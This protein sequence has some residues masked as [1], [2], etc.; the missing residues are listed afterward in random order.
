MSA[1]MAVM[2]LVRGIGSGTRQK[3]ERTGATQKLER[4]GATHLT[5][6]SL[7][8]SEIFFLPGDRK[9]SPVTTLLPVFSSRSTR[10]YCSCDDATLKAGTGKSWSASKPVEPKRRIT[11]RKSRSY[12]DLAEMRDTP[13]ISIIQ[14]SAL[15]IYLALYAVNL[16][17]RAT[18]SLK[19]GNVARSSGRPI[20]AT[21]GAP[22]LTLSRSY[23]RRIIKIQGHLT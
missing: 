11:R 1:G 12:L 5:S 6:P 9:F 23:N 10:N 3:L 7:H 20:A 15:H 4:T 2:S 14:Y 21:A 16:P 17:N 8:L 22:T 18:H 13:H 19:C